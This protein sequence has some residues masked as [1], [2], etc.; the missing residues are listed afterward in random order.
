VSGSGPHCCVRCHFVGAE[1]DS[2]DN[3]RGTRHLVRCHS[4]GAACSAS[5]RAEEI[6]AR[7]ICRSRNTSGVLVADG[8]AGLDCVGGGLAA[9]RRVEGR[10]GEVLAAV[11][12]VGCTVRVSVVPAAI[13][14]AKSLDWRGDSGGGR[15]RNSS[16]ATICWR[17]VF[18]R[19]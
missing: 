7:A 6:T 18:R 14:W 5:D 3:G 16:A 11:D 17:K 19:A 1:S 10:T 9:V 2:L 4:S 15:R 12:G 8:H 13:S